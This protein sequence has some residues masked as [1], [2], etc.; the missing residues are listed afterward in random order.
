MVTWIN[1]LCTQHM[2]SC[3]ACAIQCTVDLDT[4]M[5]LGSCVETRAQSACPSKRYEHFAAPDSCNLVLESLECF[6]N[7]C[8]I[9]AVVSVLLVQIGC[10]LASLAAFT[11]ALQQRL[12]R[13]P[14][15]RRS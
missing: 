7:L 10:L 8:I 2:S 9:A 6:H 4:L 15:T 12:S 3:Y 5:L 11:S 14:A 1:L 13:A